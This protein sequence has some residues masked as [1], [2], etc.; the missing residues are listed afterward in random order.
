[1]TRIK[2]NDATTADQR[3]ANFK[4]MKSAASIAL[5]LSSVFVVVLVSVFYDHPI[6]QTP[7]TLTALHQH[8]TALF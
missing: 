8:V 2:T 4:A 6:M 1:M 3:R 5:G 7:L